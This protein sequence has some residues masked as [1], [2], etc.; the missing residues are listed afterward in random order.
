M[1][2]KEQRAD[3]IKRALAAADAARDGGAPI[4]AEIAAAQAALESNYGSSRL[5]IKANNLFGVKAGKTW[6]G[7]RVSMPTTEI[8]AGMMVTIEAWWRSYSDWTVCFADYGHII[9]VRSCY[10][11]AVLAAHAGDALGFLD[12]LLPKIEADGTV[13]EPGWSTDPNYRDKVLSEAR[14]WGLLA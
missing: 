14:Q 3:F 8:Q 1:L 7:P 13:D 2:S 4:V 9:M 10:Q 5:A 12:G 6:N 11:D